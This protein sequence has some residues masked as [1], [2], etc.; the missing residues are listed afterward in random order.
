[1]DPLQ[2]RFKEVIEQYGYS[3]CSDQRWFRSLLRDL[4]RAKP[5]QINA[6]ADAASDGIAIEL[7]Q[8][9]NDPHKS[10]RYAQLQHRLIE[11]RGLQDGLAKWTVDMWAAAVS[12]AAEEGEPL[13]VKCPVCSNIVSFTGHMIGQILTC[14]QLNCVSRLRIFAEGRRVA[15]EAAIAEKVEKSSSVIRVAVD[16]TGQFT[17]LSDALRNAPN[18]AHI[19]LHGG[20]FEGAFVITKPTTISGADLQNR[21]VIQSSNGTCMRVQ[22]GSLRLMNVVVQAPSSVMGARRPVIEVTR[23]T[24]TFENCLFLSN[25]GE[26][27][28]IHGDG[29]NV[30]FRDCE[31][32]SDRGG[33]IVVFD[34]A[35]LNLLQCKIHGV[36]GIG[37][38]VDGGANVTLKSCRIEGA[39]T[40]AVKSRKSDINVEG[41]TIL[42]SK[43]YG[44]E[45]S[46]GTFQI[47]HS[48][49][50]E[51]GAR[52]IWV[53]DDAE[54]AIED[55]DLRANRTG[56]ISPLNST[57]VTAKGNLC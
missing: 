30:N 13:S 9:R 36:R 45:I 12:T 14:S 54:G 57:K 33:G 49:V 19:E 25:V 15:V 27:I 52:G 21:I 43:D 24:A 23:G 7:T 42:K 29:T 1:M 39:G 17:S 40:S 2:R 4:L 18:D 50:S 38:S 35:V 51:N 20:P 56:A 11:N 10:L 48:T 47:A 34:R 44:I 16:G 26:T 3:R 22:S 55:C 28:K 53:R 5:S 46:G 37:L 31:I 41:C 32:Q 8:L 6:L